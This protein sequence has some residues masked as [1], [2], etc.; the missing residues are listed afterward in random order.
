MKTFEYAIVHL[1]DGDRPVYFVGGA[2][3]ARVRQHY[4]DAVRITPCDRARWLADI[5]KAEAI[6]ESA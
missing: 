3:E 5:D 1:P 2:D 6:G 4:P